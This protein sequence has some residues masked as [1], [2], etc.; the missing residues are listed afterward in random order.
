MRI[1]AEVLLMMVA[2]LT[3]LTQQSCNGKRQASNEDSHRVTFTSLLTEMTDRESI[4]KFPDYTLKQLSSWDRTQT[5][6]E[7]PKTWFNNIDYGY[8]I[9]K[10]INN[11]RDEY[12]IMDENGPGCIVRW[13]MPLENT[14]KTRTVRFYI[15]GMEKP[16]IEE[17]C[18]NL[19]SGKSFVKEPFAFISSDE[20]DSSWQ[21]GLPVGHPKQMGANFYLPIPFSKSCKITLDDNPFYYIIGYRFYNPG[22]KVESFSL[23][24]YNSAHET[25]ARTAK[26]LTEHETFTYTIERK[27]TIQ[28]GEALKLD[29]PAGSNAVR[30]IQIRYDSEPD[31]QTLRSSV[32]QFFFDNVETVWCPVSEFF[33]GG[34]YLRTVRNWASMVT[35]NGVLQSNWVMPYQQSAFIQLRNHGSRPITVEMKIAA[36]PYTWEA[37]SM[38]FHSSWH[39]DAPINTSTPIDW[40]YIKIGGKGVY[41]GD[42]LTVHA[43]SK[44]WWGEGDEKIYLDNETFPSQL[45]TG[46]EDYYGYSW[47]MAHQFS[48]PFISVPMRDARG[49]ADWSGYTTVSRIRLLDGIPFNSALNVNVEAW[50]HDSTVSY[51]NAT[52]WYA[53][54]DATSNRKSE[55]NSVKRLLP[56]YYPQ[57]EEILPGT[58]YPDPA[59]NGPTKPE[60]DGSIKHVGNHLDY[61]TWR[62]P[63]DLKPLDADQD[64]IYGTAGYYLIYCMR[65]NGRALKF[66]DDSVKTLPDFI[67]SVKIFGKKHS[68]L[69]NSWLVDPKQPDIYI[70]TGAVMVECKANKETEI[71]K[72]RLKD[73]VPN[74]FRLGIMTDN[75]DDFNKLGKSIRVAKSDGGDSGLV[76]LATSNRVPDWYFFDISNAKPGDIIVISGISKD[77]KPWEATMGGVTFDIPVK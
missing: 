62:I 8:Y 33:G 70:I 19:M 73:P 1:R 5:G 42:V 61:L 46:L 66:L 25:I 59:S 55:E 39:E 68:V 27:Q 43:F 36:S 54:P 13:E 38:Y 22:I 56:D 48:S 44:G 9:R 72:I 51:S 7:D 17:N 6:P 67:E 3:I 57:A 64:N 11:G 76:P 63:A 29:L 50:L 10:E 24:G 32:L 28:P 14:Y 75:L 47:G 2:C 41:T 16:V 69:L 12:V 58:I 77:D 52:Y 74:V 65:F 21:Y 20:R 35:E 60:G 18:H 26:K 31:K 71:M 45:G 15:D 30:S 4:T 53:R 23:K 37:N 49:K 34:V 40:N